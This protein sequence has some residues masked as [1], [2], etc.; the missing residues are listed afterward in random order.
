MM[1]SM[2]SFLSSYFSIIFLAKGKISKSVSLFLSHTGPKWCWPI[3]LQDFKSNISLEQSNEIVYFFTCWYQKLRVDRKIL[4]WCGQKWLWPSWS[5]VNG[6]MNGWI[7][8]IYH[9][10][11]NSRKLT[12]IYFNNFWVA[13]VKNGHGTLIS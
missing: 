5:Q 7:E 4:A 3:R 6:W 2:F 12:I 9:A 13:V 10:D 1:E 11:T 8:L